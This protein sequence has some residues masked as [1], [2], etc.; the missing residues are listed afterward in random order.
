MLTFIVG[1]LGFGFALLAIVLVIISFIKGK[2]ALSGMVVPLQ[3]IHEI[4]TPGQK[5]VIEVVEK[6][7]TEQDEYGDDAPS[8][9]H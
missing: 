3:Q 2:R 8:D 1:G 5:N 7:E 6:K 4:L 9:S